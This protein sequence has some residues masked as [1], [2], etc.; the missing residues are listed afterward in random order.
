MVLQKKVHNASI[1]ALYEFD[2]SHLS[3]VPL[4][5][6]CADDSGVSTGA[7]TVTL[8]PGFEQGVHE[9]LVVDVSQRLHVLERWATEMPGGIQSEK[10]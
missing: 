4:P 3:V 10:L 7:F 2:D 1:N 9:L 8:L 6:R 5:G